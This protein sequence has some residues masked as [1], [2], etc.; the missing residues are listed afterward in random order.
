MEDVAG[1]SG[2]GFEGDK[3]EDVLFDRIIA[4]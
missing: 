4:S 3:A 1:F 2:T